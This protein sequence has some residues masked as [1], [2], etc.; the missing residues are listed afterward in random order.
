[1]NDNIIY[2]DE[3][4]IYLNEKIRK[5]LPSQQLFMFYRYNPYTIGKII[6]PERISPDA[7]FLASVNNLYKLTH[8]S[9]WIIPNIRKILPEEFLKLNTELD[10]ELE[11]LSKVIHLINGIRTLLNHNNNEDSPFYFQKSNNFMTMCKETINKIQPKN[12]DDFEKLQKKL[13]EYGDYIYRVCNMFID[14]VISSTNE[15]EIISNW[16]ENIYNHYEKNREIFYCELLN[17]WLGNL[18]SNERYNLLKKKSLWNELSKWIEESF[19][20]KYDEI[21][22]IEAWEADRE[23]LKPRAEKKMW[24]KIDEKIDNEILDLTNKIKKKKKEELEN[25]KAADFVEL[26]FKERL[27]N[28]L[29]EIAKN[30]PGI[31]LSPEYIMQE[32][33]NER[34]IYLPY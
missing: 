34:F 25:S 26:F 15:E 22:A 6:N 19:C 21:K 31:S 17:S 32:Y 7:L 20:Y 4:A 16:E 28:G 8:D 11:N 9:G 18:D 23:F 27:V 33:I 3:K 29:K 2:T 10:N 14:S 1:M 24:R 13:E 12:D 5:H 30:N